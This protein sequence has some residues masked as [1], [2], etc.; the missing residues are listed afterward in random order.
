[1]SKVCSCC[2]QV[3]LFTDF[4]KASKSKTGYG[5]RCKVCELAYQQ[6]RKQKKAETAKKWYSANRE[7][8]LANKRAETKHRRDSYLVAKLQDED[9]SRWRRQQALRA[10]RKLRA[11][12]AWVDS[13]HHSRIRQIYAATQLL[14]EVTAVVYHVDHIVPLGSDMVCGL[15]VWWNLQPMAEASNVLKNSTFD[16]RFYPEQGVVAFPSGDGLTSAQFAV[17]LES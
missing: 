4:Y 12:P 13:A 7:Q 9:I 17:L 5:N 6:G 3:K 14:Q 1:M 2:A 16:P 15:H 8:Y 10:Q 11:T